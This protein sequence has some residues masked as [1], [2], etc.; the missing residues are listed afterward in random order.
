MEVR[1]QLMESVFCFYLF[2]VSRD[3]TQVVCTAHWRPWTKLVQGETLVTN[4]LAQTWKRK[5]GTRYREL[6]SHREVCWRKAARTWDGKLKKVK[7]S[8]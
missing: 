4:S 5:E 1:R 2:W 6:V 8:S 3:Q 7:V